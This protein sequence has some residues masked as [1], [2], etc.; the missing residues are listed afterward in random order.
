[1]AAALLDALAGRPA[2]EGEPS[3]DLWNVHVLH[4]R[5]RAQL[6]AA[7]GGEPPER[8]G[9][10]PDSPAWTSVVFARAA[11]P[12]QG[13]PLPRWAVGREVR[14]EPGHALDALYLNVPLRGDFEVRAELSAAAG[15]TARVTYGGAWVGL[16]PGL[17]RYELGR[18]GRPAPDQP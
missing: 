13:Y 16:L 6:L 12:G 9:A 1:P 11:T 7:A 8:P 17:K 3:A 18:L 14:H 15:R 5:A 2:P 4:A 10:D